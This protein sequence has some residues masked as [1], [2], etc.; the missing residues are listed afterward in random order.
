[1]PDVSGYLQD[2]EHEVDIVYFFMVFLQIC[3]NIADVLEDVVDH[4]IFLQDERILNQKNRVILMVDSL[5]LGV[6][7]SDHAH[8]TDD[9]IYFSLRADSVESMLVLM[10]TIIELLKGF[11]VVR[12]VE[13]DIL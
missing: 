13:E 12:H 7:V 6:D 8:I 3:M 5:L 4:I 1:M 11:L 2:I 9:I 10:E